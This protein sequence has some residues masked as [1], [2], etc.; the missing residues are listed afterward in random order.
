MSQFIKWPLVQRIQFKKSLSR[1][2]TECQ[3]GQTVLLYCFLLKKRF[4][5]L[6]YSSAPQYQ[7]LGA[8]IECSHLQKKFL[9]VR[10]TEELG[11]QIKSKPRIKSQWSNSG[12]KQHLISPCRSC[13]QLS[14]IALRNRKWGWKRKGIYGTKINTWIADSGPEEGLLI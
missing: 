5:L 7:Q 4:R 6:C 14:R 11:C 1:P 13:M 12:L 2:R 9:S 3:C 10:C 8:L